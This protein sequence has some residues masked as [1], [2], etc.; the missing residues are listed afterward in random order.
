L[1]QLANDSG[2]STGRRA[3]AMLSRLAILRQRRALDEL[4]ELGAR[5]YTP[6]VEIGRQMVFGV[7]TVEIDDQ[8]K[9]DLQDL[10]RLKW[11]PEVEQLVFDGPQVKDEWLAPLKQMGS[12]SYITLKRAEI[13][14]AGLAHLSDVPQLHH[15]RI[16]YC[17]I[18]DLGLAR[19]K[20]LKVLAAL[21][22]FGT[23][24]TPAGAQQLATDLAAVDIDYRRGAFLGIGGSGHPQGFIVSTVHANSAAA[25]V[26][27]QS[28]DLIVKFD[29]EKV[30]D[31][32]ELTALIGRHEPGD[33]VRLEVLRGGKPLT[34][35]VELGAWD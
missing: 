17:P 27:M 19:L 5:V 35:E 6:N 33:K 32:T 26:G 7:L 12:L 18:T 24:V 15:L 21:T 10:A 2:T 30:I 23:R 9:G 31:F 1:E 29:G 20:K 11:L 22:L 16:L 4:Q 3:A 25:R 34:K 13:T 28:G 8:F 14:D